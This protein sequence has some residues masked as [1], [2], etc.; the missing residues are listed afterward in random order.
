MSKC[1]IVPD[2]LC[3]PNNLSKRIQNYKKFLFLCHVQFL[4]L[5]LGSSNRMVIVLKWTINKINKKFI[6]IPKI[7]WRPEIILLNILF[8][9]AFRP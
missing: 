2:K 5:G 3:D 9:T 7:N 8:L 4:T 1:I 6:N